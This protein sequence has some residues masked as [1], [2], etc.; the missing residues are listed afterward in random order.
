MHFVYD[1]DSTL[2]STE[3]LWQAWRGMLVAAGYDAETID[4]TGARIT[5]DGYS[6]RKHADALGLDQVIAAELLSRF[7]AVMR[8]EAPSLVFGDV[9]PFVGQR[10]GHTQSILTMGDEVHQR[11]KL[12]NSRIDLL[13]PRITIAK[14]HDTKTEY[15]K[16]ML[17]AGEEVVFI[18]DN[19]IHLVRVRE[20][21]IPVSL[22]RMRRPSEGSLVE[23]DHPLDHDAWRV[24][25][26]LDELADM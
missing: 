15:L 19:P 25:T 1:F 3:A 17:A 12:T 10:T 23:G 6:P 18:D 26:S 11:E 13:L 7:E 21:G 16:A 2:F 24:V 5:P 8:D 22:V 4:E 9:A 14:P 20:A